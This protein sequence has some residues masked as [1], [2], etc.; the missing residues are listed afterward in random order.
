[1]GISFLRDLEYHFCERIGEQHQHRDSVRHK[2][3]PLKQGV[4]PNPV[5]R[6]RQEY[7]EKHLQ[8]RLR[9][10][11]DQKS[12]MNKVDREL[13]CHAGIVDKNGDNI[14]RT[15]DDRAEQSHH[16]QL[17][18]GAL[19]HFSEDDRQNQNKKDDQ[20]RD[21]KRHILDQTGSLPCT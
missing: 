16:K 9:V 4:S 5:P 18:C 3:Q 13:V 1:M 10:M 11:E 19:S 17:V 20:S 12:R 2:Q 8:R 7:Q 6:I 21:I 15:R 14:K